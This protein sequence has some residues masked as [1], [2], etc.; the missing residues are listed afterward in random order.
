MNIVIQ[1]LRE[2]IANRDVRF[3]FPSQ[4]A[5]DLWARKTCTLGIVRS[6]AKNRFIAWDDFKKE[7]IQEKD[8]KRR[9]AT[10]VM[11][12]L[13]ADALAGKKCQRGFS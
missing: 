9:P 2:H 5:S 1:T 8:V 7:V 6:V 3:V 13:F 12:E 10:T 4:I 11:R